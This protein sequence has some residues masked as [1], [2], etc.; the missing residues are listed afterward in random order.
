[1]ER[2]LLFKKS[3]GV[4]LALCIML[5]AGCSKAP[6]ASDNTSDSASQTSRE[7]S[8]E[9][10]MVVRWEDSSSETNEASLVRVAGDS[11]YTASWSY[12][13]ETM[14]QTD[15][16][17]S[18]Q[19]KGGGQAE[20]IA[21]FEE[22]LITFLVGQDGAVYYLYRQSDGETGSCFLRKD[23]S[24]GNTEYCREAV[25]DAPE[26]D[27]LHLT[28]GA[29]G[30]KGEICFIGAEG[31]V[32]LFSAEGNFLCTPEHTWGQDW[33]EGK[34]GVINYGDELWL[35][36]MTEDRVALWPLNFAEGTVGGKEY[37]LTEK[38]PTAVFGGYGKGLYLADD[39]NLWNYAPGNSK[40]VC[41][42]NWDDNNVNLQPD[43]IEQIGILG[44]GSLFVLYWDTF[45]DKYGQAVVQEEAAS[46][47]EDRKTVILG[48][49]RKS[50]KE[51]EDAVRAFNRRN[52]EYQV[53]ILI[54]ERYEAFYEDLLKKQGADLFE[55]GN[56][57]V[58]M[59]AGKGVLEDL[60]SYF[61]QSESTREE[62]ILP[63]I[64]EAASVEDGLFCIIPSFYLRTLITEKGVTSDGGWTA[65]E[66][67]E[68]GKSRPESKLTDLPFDD[69]SVFLLNHLC[70]A[71]GNYVD[72]ERRECHF[73][74][75]SF[76][77]LLESITTESRKESTGESYITEADRLRNGEVLTLLSTV[78]SVEDYLAVKDAFADFAEI[79]GYPNGS[80]RPWYLMYMNQLYGMNSC[81]KCKEGAWAF[82]EFLLSEEYQEQTPYFPAVEAMLEKRLAAAGISEGDTI[83]EY[84]YNRYTAETKEK[85]EY[86]E[87]TDE[88]KAFIEY[89]IANT[90]WENSMEVRDIQDIIL[91]EVQAYFAGDK[92]AQETARLIQNRISLYLAE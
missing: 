33:R 85:A 69:P 41:V 64:R 55:L 29:V 72:W 8:E 27:F 86:P 57:S 47:T 54:Y 76:A 44:D 35:Y 51:L 62:D 59:L 23:S 12:D 10:T 80:G 68:L 79:A 53:E 2:K 66:F 9:E 67:M 78:G 42:L 37:L 70:V 91:E 4:V 65:E 87:L 84:V 39:R 45:T 36:E 17:V 50:D 73:E 71:I 92:S 21:D 74:D 43:Y 90:H 20:T 15:C 1:M 11:I 7:N 89:M 61:R 46:D 28:D 32:Y 14:K 49:F 24:N 77:E 81:S 83:T 25:P 40:G 13:F 75:G 26:G 60:K 48:V 88:D 16:R 19:K 22:E 3:I 5:L 58:Q 31:S 82:L 52:Q 30:S 34:G 18:L 63:C 56:M 38:E 6:A